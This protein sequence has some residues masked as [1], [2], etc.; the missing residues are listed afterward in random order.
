VPIGL[1]AVFVIFFTV[2]FKENEDTEQAFFAFLRRFLYSGDAVLYY[3]APVNQNYFARYSFTDYPAY[4]MNTIFGFLRLAP[5]KE[6]FGNVMVENALPAFAQADVIVGPN[7]PFYI[8]GKI[9]FGYYG[10]FIHSFLIGTVYA[11][12]RRTYFSLTS[13]SAFKLV[14]LGC[15][16]QLGGNVFTDTSLF[17]TLLFDTCFF[18]LPTYVIACF[19][20]NKKLVINRPSFFLFKQTSRV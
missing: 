1:L 2:L 11:F 14:F 15:L 18:V 20:V 17:V 3:Y 8:E 12:I 7:T 6:A 19:I 5:Y 10:A 9:F 13:G 4:I 16:S